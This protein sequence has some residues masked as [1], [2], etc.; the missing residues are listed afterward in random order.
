MIRILLA[1]DQAIFRAGTARV[2]GADVNLSVIGQCDR[3]E[4]LLELVAG[5]RDCVLI[6]AESLGADTNRLLAAAATVNTRV[7]LM[8]ETA[9]EQPAALTRR[10]DGLLTRQA[11]APELLACVR[12]VG[13]GERSVAAPAASAV[14]V[15]AQRMLDVL[16][17]RELQIVGFV[18][19][20]WKNRQIAEELGTKE[21][22]V[23]NYLRSIYD[24]TGSSDRLELALFTLHHRPLAEGAARACEA[25]QA[26]T[27]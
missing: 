21:Q 22:V 8:T 18:V 2:L 15:V 10:L 12:R 3:P 7:I 1:D 27:A 4:T 26:S 13:S 19:Q 14:D 23:K 24:K 20:G 6:V 5:A 11:S 25:L 9:S 16:T 17:P